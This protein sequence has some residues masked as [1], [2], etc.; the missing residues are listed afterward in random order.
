VYHVPD[1]S[2]RLL[3]HCIVIVICKYINQ[4]ALELAYR[5]P[6]RPAPFAFWKIHLLQ[7]CQFWLDSSYVRLGWFENGADRI[8]H[9]GI[10]LHF[11]AQNQHPKRQQ[12]NQDTE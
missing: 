11:L 7:S 10:Y 4:I 6:M 1:F 2:T 5:R 12:D 3:L 9:T 8:R